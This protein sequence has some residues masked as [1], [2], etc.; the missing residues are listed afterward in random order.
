MCVMIPQYFNVNHSHVYDMPIET[1]SNFPHFSI[2]SLNSFGL[3]IVPE[4]MSLIYHLPALHSMKS[5]PSGKMAAI[6]CI[7][8][9]ILRKIVPE[10]PID[11]NPA[12]I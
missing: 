5:S 9:K 8:F 11:N 7:L 1:S 4:L 6:S 12:L 2:V 10:G 3:V